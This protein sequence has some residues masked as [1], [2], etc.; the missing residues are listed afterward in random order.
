MSSHATT[1]AR[2][3]TC[4]AERKPSHMTIQIWRQK[5]NHMLGRRKA[6]MAVQMWGLKPADVCEHSHVT[7]NK[8]TIKINQSHASSQIWQQKAVICEHFI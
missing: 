6:T 5:E 4:E 1:K 7:A 8:A 3:S 2:S